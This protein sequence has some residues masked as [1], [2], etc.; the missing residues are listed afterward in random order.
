MSS[1]ALSTWV[2]DNGSLIG[3]R[4]QP[5]EYF[6]SSLL[7]PLLKDIFKVGSMKH[8]A[9]KIKCFAAVVVVYQ[10]VIAWKNGRSAF[11]I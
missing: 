10:L 9:K 3:R 2:E 6:S 1:G 4:D 11:Q 7:L 5:K 8:Y